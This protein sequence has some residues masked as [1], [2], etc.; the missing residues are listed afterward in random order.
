MPPLLLLLLPPLLLVLVL[1]APLPL[2][3]LSEEMEEERDL[4]GRGV[5]SVVVEAALRSLVLLLV[6]LVH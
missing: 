4:L 1:L 5:A 6:V 3:P 2:P